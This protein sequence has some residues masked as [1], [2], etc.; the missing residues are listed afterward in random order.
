MVIWRKG[1][2]MKLSLWFNTVSNRQHSDPTHFASSHPTMKC[3]V[4][5][6]CQHFAY[7]SARNRLKNDWNRTSLQKIKWYLHVSFWAVQTKKQDQTGHTGGQPR[8]RQGQKHSRKTSNWDDMWT[9][10]CWEARLPM[11]AVISQLRR[12]F[13]WFPCSFHVVSM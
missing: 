3:R 8:S 13:A 2:P 5:P 11:C 9:I 6:F 7:H 4:C 1:S 10:H 12:V